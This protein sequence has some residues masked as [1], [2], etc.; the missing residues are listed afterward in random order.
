VLGFHA[1]GFF[2]IFNPSK[3][4]NVLVNPYL[5]NVSNAKYLHTR[6]PQSHHANAG[7]QP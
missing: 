4:K 3:I 1:T 7:I 2:F 5:M 6:K